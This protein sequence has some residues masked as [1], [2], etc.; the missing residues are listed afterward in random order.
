MAH[1]I[2]QRILGDPRTRF[3]ELTSRLLVRSALTAHLKLFH[4]CTCLAMMDG[5]PPPPWVLRLLELH[6]SSQPEV[7]VY[8]VRRAARCERTSFPRATARLS[9]LVCE[10]SRRACVVLRNGDKNVP[11]KGVAVSRRDAGD[12]D[13]TPLILVGE[14]GDGVAL[15]LTRTAE[16]PLGIRSGAAAARRAGCA[17][18]SARSHL[19]DSPLQRVSVVSA[20]C[21]TPVIV[22]MFTTTDHTSSSDHSRAFLFFPTA[23]DRRRPP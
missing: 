14:D 4:L 12:G 10:E 1:A 3:H 9:P 16:R 18:A 15:I 19:H 13:R 17:K 21:A 22:S 6:G 5:S 11:G 20:R 23:V 2:R 8:F 7:A